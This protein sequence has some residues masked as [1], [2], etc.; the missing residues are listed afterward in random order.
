[1]SGTWLGIAGAVL[2]LGGW[3]V[4]M[5][6]MQQVRIPRNRAGFFAV[7]GSSVGLGVAALVS[8]TGIIGGIAAALAILGGGMFIGLRLQSTQDAREPS[9]KVG[10]PIL[11][12]SAPDDTG[13][14]FA[15]ASLRGSPFLLKFFRG[16]W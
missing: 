12:F 3:A 2:T 5:R 7:F 4:W 14:S 10:E 15:L 6:L 13:A 8:G 11:D 16:H 9:V 1:M